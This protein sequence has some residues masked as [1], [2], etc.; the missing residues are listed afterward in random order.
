MTNTY[1][2]P[3]WSKSFPSRIHY[4]KA[5][6]APADPIAAQDQVEGGYAGRGPRRY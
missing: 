2:L 6:G 5:A 3:S 4:W 1:W